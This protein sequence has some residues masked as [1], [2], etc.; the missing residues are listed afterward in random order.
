VS[1][2]GVTLDFY[3]DGGAT[4]KRFFASAE[5]LPE[6]IKTASVQKP[7]QVSDDAFALT[8][9]DDGQ[10]LKKFAC[11]DAGTTAMSVLYF[12]THGDKLPD[13]AQKTA[14]MALQR[15]CHKY[16]VGTEGLLKTAGWWS[17]FLQGAGRDVAAG[18]GPRVAK[19]TEEAAGQAAQHFR[20]AGEEVAERAAQHFRGAGDDLL[21]K[22][23][24]AAE[25][26]VRRAAGAA[27]E[28]G[29]SAGRRV[30]TT[31]GIGAGAGA[32]T[33]APGKRWEGAQEGAA[34]GVLGGLAGASVGTPH[35]GAALAGGAMGLKPWE[36]A[37]GLADSGAVDVTGMEPAPKFVS[38]RP[39]DENLFAV[40]L[41]D[42]TQRYPI[43]TWTQVKQASAYFVDESVR[44]DP[45]TRH[46]FAT[47]LAARAQAIGF[48]MPEMVKTAGLVERVSDSSLNAGLQMRINAFPCGEA[49]AEAKEALRHIFEKRASLTS[50]AMAEAIHTFDQ[51]F[52]LHTQY[53]RYL[54]D[55]WETVFEKVKVSKFLWEDGA[56]RVTEDELDNLALNNAGDLGEIFAAEGMIKGFEKD[57]I[58]VFKSLPD[59]HKRVVA[60][61]AH[62]IANSGRSSGA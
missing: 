40:T 51:H 1:Y 48:D 42:G 50:D 33:A 27:G 28:I 46:Q 10:V 47:N 56:S 61:L 14:A 62:S 35:M 12:L 3:D 34:A 54:P 9:L 37:A 26:A 41:S 45:A 6:V 29:A 57:P 52:G 59:T 53:R 30:L 43:G 16:E 32:L 4:L 2:S 17:R 18:A 36:K 31:S 19:A 8:M 38:D 24:E 49:P 23:P 44:M 5:D 21:K 60:R 15:A 20:G 25:E 22:A 7:L 39:S 55:P 13:L 58:G 11:T